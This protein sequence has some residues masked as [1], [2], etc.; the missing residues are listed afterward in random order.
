MKLMKLNFMITLALSLAAGCDLPR[1]NPLDENSPLFNGGNQGG[2][3][4]EKELQYYSSRVVVKYAKDD[5][6]YTTDN[7]IEP[8]DRVFLRI[9]VQNTGDNKLEKLRGTI[10]TS[11]TSITITGLPS[12]YYLK[13]TQDSDTN[14]FLDPNK[15]GWGTI[16]NGSSYRFAD[17]GS[18]YAVEFNV[19]ENA[20]SGESIG[21]QLTIKD[22]DGDEWMEN[23]TLKV[24]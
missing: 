7:T 10:T 11:S 12:G 23:F 5:F 21:F 17:D 8:G 3:T 15:I 18:S 24:Q 6:N 1:D 19:S 14:D 16:T 22:K 2:T 20:T 4:T 9:E 13:F